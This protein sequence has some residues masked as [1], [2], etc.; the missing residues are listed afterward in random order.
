[1]VEDICKN[2]HVVGAIGERH[3]PAFV[4]MDGDGF[5]SSDMAFE[6]FDDE[7]LWRAGSTHECG[8]QGTDAATDVEDAIAFAKVRQDQLDECAQARL[9]H[10]AVHGGHGGLEW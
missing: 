8:A 2:D 7:V 1:M 9:I 3:A 10:R 5:A 4:P 6:A